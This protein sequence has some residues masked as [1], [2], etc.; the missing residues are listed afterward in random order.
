MTYINKVRIENFQSHEDTLM[1][2]HKGL[3]VITGP[4]DHGKSAVMRAIKWVLYNEPRG[5]DFI[6]QGTASARVTLEFS[7]GHTIIRE[8]SKSKN[9]YTVLYPDGSDM[10]LEGFGNEVPEEVVKV[11]G[12]SKVVLDTDLST[13]LNIGE[14]LEG[15]FLLSETPS[16]RAKA[17]GRLT[18]LHIID[19][20]IRDSIVDIRRESQT[21]DR[22]RGELEDIILKLDSYREL[23][24]WEARIRQ[25]EDTT[26]RLELLISQSQTLERYKSLLVQYETDIQEMEDIMKG[27]QGLDACEALIKS[28]E[29]LVSR[30][31]KLDNVRNA[32]Q[33]IM[34]QVEDCN[35]VLDKSIHI[36]ECTELVEKAIQKVELFRRLT[37]AHDSLRRVE[38]E[39]QGT[40]GILE[41]TESLPLL[42]TIAY[43]AT[44]NVKRL[45]TSQLLHEK[46][47]QWETENT[48]VQ[49]YLMKSEGVPECETAVREISH[50]RE[51]LSQLEAMHERLQQVGSQ[52]LEGSRYLDKNKVELEVHVREFTAHLKKEG[53]CPLC[54]SEI[55]EMKLKD[56]VKHYE[57]V[58]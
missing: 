39:Q 29:V 2:F 55:S 52:V 56:L 58:H 26:R 30:T 48:K 49:A 13:S 21:E 38:A 50:R 51:L 32:F 4:S 6:R 8:R 19:K 28:S 40:E 22:I 45:N 11:H 24:Q 16:V 57:E 12:I 44:E 5:M 36:G 34:S 53:K 25:T 17:I 41:K 7:N 47:R 18:G 15:P 37:A 42:E 27:L 10:V 54:S 1:E 46:Y 33:Q 35:A 3:N 20:S 9:K 43:Q 14:Q 31:G 23:E